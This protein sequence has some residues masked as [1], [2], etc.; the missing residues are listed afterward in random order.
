MHF[1]LKKI[2]FAHLLDAA[3]IHANLDDA[4]VGL[5]AAP[6]FAGAPAIVAHGRGRGRGRGGG[7]Q[8]GFSHTPLTR[9][10]IRSG[11]I[12]S[13]VQQHHHVAEHIASSANHEQIVSTFHCAVDQRDQNPKV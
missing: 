6:V 4:A 11:S 13:T 10:R 2:M 7:R 12:H 3:S 1:W 9:E 8:R 5:F